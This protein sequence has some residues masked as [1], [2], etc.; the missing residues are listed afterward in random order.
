MKSYLERLQALRKLYSGCQ[1][2]SSPFAPQKVYVFGSTFWPTEETICNP[3]FRPVS[4]RG[5]ALCVKCDY[6]SEYAEPGFTCSQ[7]KL[8]GE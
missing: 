5:W 2:I 7:C 3:S 1:I 6:E 8:L 4:P